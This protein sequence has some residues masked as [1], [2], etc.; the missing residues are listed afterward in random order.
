MEAIKVTVSLCLNKMY[1]FCLFFYIAFIAFNQWHCLKDAL[2][3]FGHYNTMM[4]EYLYL[5]SIVHYMVCRCIVNVLSCWQ[6]SQVPSGFIVGLRLVG[7]KSILVLIT[8][9]L[10]VMSTTM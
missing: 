7:M 8:D 9:L 2:G 6:S 5:C 1:T 10:D 4:E 3:L